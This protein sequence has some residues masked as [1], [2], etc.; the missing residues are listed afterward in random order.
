MKLVNLRFGSLLGEMIILY[1]L[2][3]VLIWHLCFT[4]WIKIEGKETGFL[5]IFF[6]VV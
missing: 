1:T 2:Y 4:A 3:S 6:S 5:F